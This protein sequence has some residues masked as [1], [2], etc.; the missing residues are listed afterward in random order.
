MK[1]PTLVLRS[2]LHADDVA[3]RIRRAL[4]AKRTR[5]WVLGDQPMFVVHGEGRRLRIIANTRSKGRFKSGYEVTVDDADGRAVVEGHPE[6]LCVSKVL[7]GIQ[8]FIAAC[9]AYA[10][11]L[12]LAHGRHLLLNPWWYALP[13]LVPASVPFVWWNT[14]QL[15]RADQG[16][17][18]DA[19]VGALRGHV[20]GAGPAS[21]QAPQG[22]PLPQAPKP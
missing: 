10:V 12:G 15:L 16:L 5:H 18:E 14:R 2:D 11:A 7:L 20:L 3:G 4:D 6:L 19:I 21:G 17:I 9:F 13:L 1:K 8:V 22:N